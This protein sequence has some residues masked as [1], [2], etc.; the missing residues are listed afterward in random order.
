MNALIRNILIATSVGVILATSMVLLAS[1]QRAKSP[2]Q[3][4]QPQRSAS[5]QQST[6]THRHRHIPDTPS[7][8]ELVETDEMEHSDCNEMDHANG[9][10]PTNRKLSIEPQGLS[11]DDLDELLVALVNTETRREKREVISRLAKEVTEHEEIKEAL[12]QQF[13]RESD[14]K[15]QILLLKALAKTQDLGFAKT[16]ETLVMES[17]GTLVANRALLALAK[18]PESTA[19]PSLLNIAENARDT[20]RERAIRLLVKQFPSEPE[21]ETLWAEL[22]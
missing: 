4:R 9:F 1:T 10:E 17:R 12:L 20:Q 8:A 5:V 2:I 18:Y 14:E 15:I 13:S 3:V 19:F 21:T 22:N 11:A 7:Q 6:T 16:L